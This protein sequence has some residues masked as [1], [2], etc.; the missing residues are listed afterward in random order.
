MEQ[1]AV[2]PTTEQ[3]AAVIEEELLVEEISI[4]GMCGV[5]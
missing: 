5:Y 4:D 2:T 1:E 3:D